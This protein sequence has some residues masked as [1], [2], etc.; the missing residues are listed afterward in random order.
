VT[1]QGSRS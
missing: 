1:D